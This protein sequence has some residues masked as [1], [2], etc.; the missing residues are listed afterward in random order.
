MQRK[1]RPKLSS[2]FSLVRVEPR[3]CSK[4]DR[5]PALI[6][7]LP[8]VSVC[9]SNFPSFA[10]RAVGACDSPRAPKESHLPPIAVTCSSNQSRHMRALAETNDCGKKRCAHRTGKKRET[11]RGRYCW[12]YR[13]VIFGSVSH[14]ALSLSRAARC[15]RP[16]VVA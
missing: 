3:S 9:G 6:G 7:A 11:R 15:C 13:G 5:G 4:G 1:M 2:F 16:L 14:L 10:R 8:I 12:K